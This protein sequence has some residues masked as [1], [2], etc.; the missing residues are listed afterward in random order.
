VKAIALRLLKSDRRGLRH[1]P[2]QYRHL[3]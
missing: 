3:C 1:I 2:E